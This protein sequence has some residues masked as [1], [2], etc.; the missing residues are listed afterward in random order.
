MNPFDQLNKEPVVH[1]SKAMFDYGFV[2]EVQSEA[3]FIYS[4]IKVQI[5][6]EYSS[7]SITLKQLLDITG[8]SKSV[9]ITALNRLVDLNFLSITKVDRHLICKVIEKIPLTDNQGNMI[10]QAIWTYTPKLL[11][12]VIR[13]LEEF[14]SGKKLKKDLKFIEIEFIDGV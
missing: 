8:L 10:A 3:F 11:N 14:Q 2:K 1:F 13:E 6:D 5:Q 7:V 12:Q 9:V 4:C